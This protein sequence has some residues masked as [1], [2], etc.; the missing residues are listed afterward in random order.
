MSATAV[1]SAPILAVLHTAP[2]FTVPAGACDCH[3]HVFGPEATF[4][5]SPHRRYRPGLATHEDLA[6]LQR[7]LRLDRVVIVQPSCYGADNGCTLDGVRRLGRRAR[8]VAVIDAGTAAPAL[9]DM[10][11]AGV[12]GVR[13]NL[14][15]EGEHDPRIA[16]RLLA[17]TAARVAPLGW[18]VQTYTNIG[19]IAALH[20][21]IAALPVPL[22]I[23]H[24][25]LARA[26]LGPAQAGFDHLVALVRSGKVYVKLSA[27]YR[28]SEAPDYADAAAIARALIDANPDRMLWG[29][30][31]PHP[32]VRHGAPRD[33][34]RIEPF[35]PEDDGRAL[36]RLAQWTRDG[37]EL[38]KI[39]VANPARLYDFGQ[40]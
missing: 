27:A 23:D 36:N 13:V 33:P 39:L 26:A 37:T 5:L 28:I 7:A 19:V 31:W 10:H 40:T 15:T 25:G 2:G 3:T 14:E 11:A 18:H 22:V 20:D 4:P 1:S 21:T 16:G 17:E 32:G 12:R 35:R 30:D 34:G 9:D 6:A 38:D 29:S 8:A 24:F